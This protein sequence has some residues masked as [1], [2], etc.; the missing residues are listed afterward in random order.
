MKLLIIDDEKPV[1]D[2]IKLLIPK[3]TYK[4]SEI[5]E[6]E[7]GLE[8]VQLIRQYS[9]DLIFTDICMPISDGLELMDWIVENS[10]ST[11]VIA[12]SGYTDYEY[13]RNFFIKGGLDYIL[14]PIQPD[15]LNLAVQKAQGEIEKK[16]VITPTHE[17]DYITEDIFISIKKYIDQN[18]SNQLTLPYIA[19]EFHLSEPYLSRKFKAKVDINIIQDIKVVRIRH[20]KQLLMSS[21]K[22]ISEIALLVGYDDEKYFSRVFKEI[23]K[24]SAND[25]R[26]KFSN[27]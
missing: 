24:I 12:I 9:P 17:E 15:K 14:K 5:F 8:A 6:A 2:C 21:R 3:N 16:K 10:V 1:R 23:E 18:Y 11:P 13:I 27:K 26:K 4:I 20:A 19:S 7:D 25:Y 22:K